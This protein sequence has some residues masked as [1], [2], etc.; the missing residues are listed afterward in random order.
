MD[1]P[2]HHHKE[3]PDGSSFFLWE[4][5]RQHRFGAVGLV[6]GKGRLPAVGGGLAGVVFSSRGLGFVWPYSLMI[7]GMNSNKTEDAL[8][9]SELPFVLS[10][11]V[12][13]A[14]FLLVADIL[15]RKQD[16]KA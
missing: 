2:Q 8:A 15:L 13:L 10:C 16:V 6:L 11:L 7:A 1:K 12:F 9:G 4:R 14:V 3:E 5:Q